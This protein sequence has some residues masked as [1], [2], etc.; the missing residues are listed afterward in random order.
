VRNGVLAAAVAVISLFSVTACGSSTSTDAAAS[1][2]PV[3][4]VLSDFMIMPHA[5]QA[6]AG[7]V[8]FNVRNDG[9]SPHDFSIR[10]LSNKP[11]EATRTLNPGDNVELTKKLPAGDYIVYCSVAGHE[12]LGMKGTLKVA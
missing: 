9:Q 7:T 6:T 12:S 1:G 5:F 4:V 3:S 11:V 8:T 2:P 10:D